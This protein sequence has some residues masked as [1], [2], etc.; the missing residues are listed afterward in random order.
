MCHVKRFVGL[1]AVLAVAGCNKNSDGTRAPGEQVAADNA[2]AQPSAQDNADAQP[3]AQDVTDA[4]ASTDL[5]DSGFA[6]NGDPAALPPMRCSGGE[7]S[8]AF[9]VTPGG[10]LYWTPKAGE[11]ITLDASSSPAGEQVW[12][13]RITQQ[14]PLE[15]VKITKASCIDSQSKESFSHT[16]F[17]VTKDGQELQG[18]CKPL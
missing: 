5:G 10:K 18:C 16:T 13:V 6:P 4:Q 9:E 11:E 14:A 8:W 15:S 12:T 1:C 2:D 3:S 17:V 7:T